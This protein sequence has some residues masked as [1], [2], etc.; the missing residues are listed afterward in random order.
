M[1]DIYYLLSARHCSKS[2]TS[3]NPFKVGSIIAL[4]LQV[5]K[6]R[7]ETFNNLPKATEPVM[8]EQNAFAMTHEGRGCCGAQ[9]R[10]EF[11]LPGKIKEDFTEEVA[12]KPS[13]KGSV[14]VCQVGIGERAFQAE[15]QWSKGPEH[16]QVQGMVQHG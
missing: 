6:C 8:A 16:V 5:R 3:I 2:F 11:T 10:K 13:I 7:H 15:G 12:F 4:I 14:G 1:G 9:R